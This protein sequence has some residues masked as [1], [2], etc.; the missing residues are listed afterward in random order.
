[1]FS[2]RASEFKTLTFCRVEVSQLPSHHNFP[3]WST[4][5]LFLLLQPVS[6]TQMTSRRRSSSCHHPSFKLSLRADLS[7]YVLRVI[8]PPHCVHELNLS[9]S[10]LQRL[11]NQTVSMSVDAPPDLAEQ[12]KKQTMQLTAEIVRLQSAHLLGYN[13][14]LSSSVRDGPIRGQQAAFSSKG[15]EGR[16][17]LLIHVSLHSAI[18][19]I[20]AS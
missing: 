19:P 12:E 1:M 8:H 18:S 11:A 9:Q 13:A 20:E 4:K 3:T 17:V 6:W 10:Y 14:A 15:F 2:L 16:R 5:T 7:E